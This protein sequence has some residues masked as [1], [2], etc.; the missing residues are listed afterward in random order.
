MS[1]G[2]EAE[3]LQDADFPYFRILDF[4]LKEGGDNP[5]PSF[6]SLTAELQEEAPAVWLTVRNSEGTV[7]RRI[8]GPASKGFH[9]VNWNLRYPPTDVARRGGRGGGFLAAPGEYTVD[10]TK[11]VRGVTTQLVAPMPFT[12]EPLRSDSGALPRQPDAQAFAKDVEKFDRAV[13]A[14]GFKLREAQQKVRLLAVAARSAPNGD[15]ATLDDRVDQIRGEVNALDEL[16]NGNPARRAIN[17]RTQPTV[18]SRLGRAMGNLYGS[19]YGPTQTQRD[20]LAYAKADFDAVRNRLDAL[21]RS[22]IPAFEAELLAMGA[23]YVPGGVLPEA[24]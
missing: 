1:K 2:I 13:T 8:K 7:V 24:Q 3:V 23:P 9:R 22:T 15:P 14:L 6:E 10:L 12:V 21:T 11:R 20:Q 16:L 5:F 18:R 17:E 4:W 19:T